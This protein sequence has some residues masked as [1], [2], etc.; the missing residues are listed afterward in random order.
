MNIESGDLVLVIRGPKSGTGPVKS[1]KL[2]VWT[3]ESKIKEVSIFEQDSIMKLWPKII[4]IFFR[5]LTRA[6]VDLDDSTVKLL[7]GHTEC[8]SG[9]SE[10]CPNEQRV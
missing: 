3:C 10:N 5:H 8:L 1:P 6:S 7:R 9:L 2:E 4:S